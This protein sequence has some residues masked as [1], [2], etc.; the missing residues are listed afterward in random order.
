MSEEDARE[1]AL[2]SLHAVCEALAEHGVEGSIMLACLAK[3]TAEVL[4]DAPEAS[5]PG[6]LAALIA[7]LPELVDASVK[8]IAL[9]EAAALAEA[10]VAGTA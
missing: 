9:Y 8:Q 10:E 2:G 6:L 3:M 4:A 1:L 5:R 7:K